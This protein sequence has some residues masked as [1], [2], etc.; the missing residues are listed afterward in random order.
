MCSPAVVWAVSCVYQVTWQ[1]PCVHQVTCAVPCVYQVTCAVPYVHQVTWAVLCV[2]QVTCAVGYRVFIKSRARYRMFIRWHARYRVFIKSH[3]RYCVFI[4]WRVPYVRQ[5]TL[6]CVH[7]ESQN[8]TMSS[9]RC[10][11]CQS[12]VY[13]CI[14]WCDCMTLLRDLSVAA[15]VFVVAVAGWSWRDF[16]VVHTKADVAVTCPDV[17]ALQHHTQIV[18][19]TLQLSHFFL[20]P[21][22]LVLQF[23][24]LL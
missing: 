3:A 24:C 17:M 16:C 6:S 11:W 20:E 14:L 2:R 12:S 1:V 13:I 19:L 9:H 23:L 7:R 22:L 4:R 15:V 5:D 8:K 21:G 18:S 10:Q